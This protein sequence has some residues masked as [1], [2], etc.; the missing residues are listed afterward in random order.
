VGG[1][2]KELVLAAEGE[3]VTPAQPL[4][5]IVPGEETLVVEAYLTNKDVGF[6]REKM[7]AVVKIHTFPFTKYGLIDAQVVQISADAL[8]DKEQGLIYKVRLLLKRD[9]L[10]VEGEKVYLLPGM[11][12]TAEVKTG[13][14]RL[15]EYFLA[16]LLRYRQ[17]SARE[18]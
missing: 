13:T 5:Q 8:A 18:R 1:V 3:V 12:V 11:A 6:V 7:S 16:P 14:R 9:W 2:V 15:I 17:E 10:D 4:M